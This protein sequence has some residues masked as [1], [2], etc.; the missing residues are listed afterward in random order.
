[1]TTTCVY[2]PFSASLSS[3]AATVHALTTEASEL[4]GLRSMSSSQRKRLRAIN[5]K[6]DAYE[7][8]LQDVDLLPVSESRDGATQ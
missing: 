8:V 4:L 3:A 6:L 2:A 7:Q 5:S 1:M